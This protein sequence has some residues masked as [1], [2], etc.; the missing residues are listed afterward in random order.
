MTTTEQ[1]KFLKQ[2]R[3]ILASIFQDRINELS[4]KMITEENPDLRN[5][6]RELIVEL[7]FWLRDINVFPKE[8]KTKKE[9]FI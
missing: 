6:Y 7:R 8:R 9:N 5:R 3:A 4:E 2:N 1:K